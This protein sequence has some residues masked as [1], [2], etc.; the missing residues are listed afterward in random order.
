M[1]K[2]N[3]KYNENHLIVYFRLIF[4][5]NQQQTKDFSL[6]AKYVTIRCIAIPVKLAISL[7]WDNLRIDVYGFLQLSKHFLEQHPG[8]FLSPLRISGSAVET[9]FSQYKYMA[10]SKLDA[11]N[12]PSCRS[13]YLAKQAVHHSGQFYRDQDLTIPLAPLEKKQYNKLRK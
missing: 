3:H 11:S 10:G 7:A 2:V 5:C 12:Y 4:L 1:S 13:K 9:L 8:Y 6:L